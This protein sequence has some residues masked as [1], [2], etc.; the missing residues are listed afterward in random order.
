[1][2]YQ[3]QIERRA[4][5]NLARIAEPDRSRLIE[6]IRGL[7]DEPRPQGSKKLSGRGGWRVRVGD[8]RIL[9]DIHDA[10]LV[11]LVVTLGHRRD[12]YR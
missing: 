4:Q 7:A 2:S 1:L 11:V 3:V 12:V 9:Y 10:Q 6:A 8:Y 5:K